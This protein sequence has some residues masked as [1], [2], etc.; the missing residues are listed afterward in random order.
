MS[1]GMRV[2]LVWTV[3]A[4]V[5]WGTA[6]ALAGPDCNESESSP[7]V[8]VDARVD[9]GGRLVHGVEIMGEAGGGMAQ[10]WDT[11]ELTDG[12]QEVVRGTNRTTVAVA[13]GAGVAVEYGR[14]GADATWKSNRVHVVRNWVA[15]PSGR[16]LEIA[17]GTV[18]KF[19]RGTGILVEEGGTL[20]LKGEWNAPV[21]MTAAEDDSAGGDTDMREEMSVGCYFVDIRGNVEDSGWTQCWYADMAES[22]GMQAAG[23]QVFASMLPCGESEWSAAARL[24]ARAARA[25][26]LLTVGDEWATWDTAWDGASRV[27]VELERPD[28][29]VALLGEAEGDGWGSAGWTADASGR[30]EVRYEAWD[31]AGKVLRQMSRGLVRLDGNAVLHSGRVGESE[32]WSAG[33]VHVLNGTVTVERGSVLTIERGAVVKFAGGSALVVENGGTCVAEGVV[34]T[35]VN[36]D[37]I[38]G[39]TMGDGNETM[40]LNDD[41]GISGSIATDAATELRYLTMQTSGTLN[42]NTVW[43][44]N[45]V[46]RVTGD[47]TVPSGTTL[48]V[49]PGAVVKFDEGM[50][51]T[52][53]GGGTLNAIGTRAQPIVFTS[54]KDDE[55]GGDTNGDGDATAAQPGDW[56]KIEVYGTAN[57]DHAKV[58]YAS[59][60]TSTDDAILVSGGSVTFNNSELGF[61]QMYAVGVESGHFHATN[62]VIR[63]FY[64]AFRHWPYDPFVN[65]VIYNCNRL[66]NNSGQQFCN[67]VI[68]GV[69]EA[70]DWSSGI[71]NTYGHCLFWNEPGTGLQ[72]LPGTA[73]PGDGNVWGN[74]LF[75]DAENG[76]FRVRAGSACI[77]A[78][79]GTVAPETDYFG[80]P[81]MNDPNVADTGVANTNGVC[82]D[83]GIYEME[84]GNAASDVDLEAVRVSASAEALISVR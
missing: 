31:A 9:F 58:F 26:T 3:A 57:F 24:D 39:D 73:S 25:G 66:S 64:C 71:G 34:F 15:V 60:G 33:T 78:G 56:N 47:V 83:I 62:S 84:G 41:Y 10:A 70:W 72:G 20:R 37:T 12:W 21:R 1:K 4:S 82:P 22:A 61:G 17:A 38:G 28:G 49:M 40:P 67:T 27:R 48:T 18:V 19:T 55:H 65:G 23:M 77:D 43:M 68:A 42:G 59:R 2:A 32:T 6:W 14:M 79:D 7:A 13:N 54:V 11:R 30:Y 76:D 52:V 29:T 5:A 69:T 75:V 46:I 53:N 16:T 35:H 8:R 36:D 51:L 45:R 63:E 81:R 44:G 74:P 50:S 80:R